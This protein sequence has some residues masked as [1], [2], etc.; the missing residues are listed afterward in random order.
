MEH[1]NQQ[2]EVS[3]D[4]IVMPRETYGL[5]RTYEKIFCTLSRTCISMFCWE[6]ERSPAEHRLVTLSNIAA[7][8]ELHSLIPPTQHPEEYVRQLQRMREL[9]RVYDTRE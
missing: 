8:E 2:Q 5:F 4:T 6:D 7:Y 3:I 9:P 1:K